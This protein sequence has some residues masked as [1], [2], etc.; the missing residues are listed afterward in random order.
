MTR[1]ADIQREQGSMAELQEI[2]SAMRALAGMRLQEAQQALPAVRRYSQA[3]AQA[4]G[5]ALML[6]PVSGAATPSADR[7]QRALIVC[8]SEHG[9][10]GGFNERLMEA[11]AASLGTDDLL[12]MVGS[13]GV[14]LALERE[15][16]IAWSSAMATRVA[17]TPDVVNALAAEL[18]T[19]IAGGGIGRVEVLFERGEQGERPAVERR[20]LLPLDPLSLPRV[21]ARQAALHDLAP[22]VL[23]EKLI[24]EYVF[25]LLT[26][27]TV[28]SL[29][30]ENA[31][32]FAAMQSAHD[33]ISK[34]LTQLEQTAEEARQSEITSELL[35][36]ITGAEA[37]AAQ[38]TPH[39]HGG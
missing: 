19:R 25:A 16:Q 4:I 30:S 37:L 28:E 26:E 39:G 21:T 34:R 32:R 35:D 1:L 6:L 5:T 38:V 13:R 31:A 8:C 11:A 22:Y 3:M 18:Y 24:A 23:A 14:A 27:A 17:G 9:F 20:R 15:R 36:L 29:A 10:V 2:V 7:G 12:F 33:S